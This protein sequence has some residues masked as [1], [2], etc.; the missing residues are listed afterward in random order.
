MLVTV[1]FSPVQSH[2]RETNR[3]QVRL[4]CL[5]YHRFRVLVIYKYSNLYIIIFPSTREEQLTVKQSRSC[6][7]LCLAGRWCYHIERFLFLGKWSIVAYFLVPSPWTADCRWRSFAF[8]CSHV[9]EFLARID[10]IVLDQLLQ[11]PS[12]HPQQHWQYEHSLF[13]WGRFLRPLHSSL[14][15]AIFKHLSHICAH[16]SICLRSRMHS[17]IQTNNFTF[18]WVKRHNG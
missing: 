16:I 6:R 5:L 15:K 4:C 13:L 3:H 11:G 1:Y 8:R 18:G 10:C 12:L 2:R 17:Q 7:E 14:E 9:Q